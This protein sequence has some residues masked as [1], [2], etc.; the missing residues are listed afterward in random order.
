[1]IAALIIVAATLAAAVGGCIAFGVRAMNA[2]DDKATAVN[3][4]LVAERDRDVAN[5]ARV[6]ATAERDAA[7]AQLVKTQRLAVSNAEGATNDVR[8][9]A[10][11]TDA[12]GVIDI[13]GGLLAEPLSDDDP[14]DKAS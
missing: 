13:V 7:V 10:A 11:A 9:R 8:T 14:D 2:T 5:A 3:E 1:V 6:K 4:R 12:A